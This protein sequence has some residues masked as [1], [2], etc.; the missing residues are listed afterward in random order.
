[1]ELL[2]LFIKPRGC[3]GVLRKE[4]E[5]RDVTNDGWDAFKDE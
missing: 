1:L 5:D 2:F 4:E 3:L